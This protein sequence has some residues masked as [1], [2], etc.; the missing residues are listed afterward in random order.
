MNKDITEILKNWPYAPGELSARKIVGLDGREKVQLRVDLGLLQIEIDGRPDAVRPFGSDSL[1]D[2]Y[3]N[4]REEHAKRA[5]EG[6]PFSLSPAE[7]AALREESVQYYFRYLA[8]FNL[9]EYVHVMRDT[10]RNLRLFD[11]MR[12]WAREPGDKLALEIYRPYVI[13]MHAR[14]KALE[15]SSRKCLSE[16]IGALDEG[17]GEIE[18]F[19]AQ[20]DQD[21]SEEEPSEIRVLRQ[22]RQELDKVRKAESPGEAESL[23][24][25]LQ[26]KLQEAVSRE[27]FELA[28]R[29]RDQIRSIEE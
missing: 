26:K 8:M 16:A 11:F 14:G 10:A 23:L 12:R 24:G 18:R 7:C 5:A 13:M 28:A 17:I 6:T 1:L 27:Q 29:L 3:E 25:R 22:L 9:G 15:L 2:Y 20:Y 4:K 19:F 21:T